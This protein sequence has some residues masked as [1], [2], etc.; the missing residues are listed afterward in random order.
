MIFTKICKCNYFSYIASMLSDHY[1]FMIITT[2]DIPVLGGLWSYYKFRYSV[3]QYIYQYNIITD[4][5]MVPF[6]ICCHLIIFFP[7]C[8]YFLSLSLYRWGNR[9]MRDKSKMYCSSANFSFRAEPTYLIEI[10]SMFCAKYYNKTYNYTQL[11]K[12]N[13]HGAYFISPRKFT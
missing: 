10:I 1:V 13:I 5:T 8:G 2:C 4:V 7:L 11:M 3:V 12:N 6:S 9:A